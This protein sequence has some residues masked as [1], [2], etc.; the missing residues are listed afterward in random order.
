MWVGRYDGWLDGTYVKDVGIGDT[1]PSS[2]WLQFGDDILET[3]IIGSREL[4]G[5]DEHGT[6]RTAVLSAQSLQPQREGTGIVER[7][8]DRRTRA[9][10][11]LAYSGSVGL[12][13]PTSQTSEMVGKGNSPPKT[14]LKMT[15]RIP[16]HFLHALFC[17]LSPLLIDFPLFVS[18]KL[19]D[20]LTAFLMPWLGCGFGARLLMR[21]YSPDCPGQALTIWT[22]SK[23]RTR[24]EMVHRNVE[25]IVGW[26]MYTVGAGARLSTRTNGRIRGSNCY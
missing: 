16:Y 7:K 11:T 26:G 17:G 5:I 22:R 3:G 4:L 6:V 18:G 1:M 21:L 9:V 25:N 12:K 24:A 10:S 20:L 14:S 13:Q 19:S 2:E 23:L 15:S 8:P